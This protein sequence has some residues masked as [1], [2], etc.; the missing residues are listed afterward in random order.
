MA[1]G[2]REEPKYYMEMAVEVMKNSI[3][4]RNQTDPSP[5]VGAVLVFPN[6]DVNTAYRGQ[7]REGDHAEYTV[8]DK[9]NRHRD[10]SE[11]W[12]FATL[13]PCAPGA[14]KFPKLS[15]ANRIVNARIS[16]VWFG[17][18]ELNSK[19]SGG[20]QYLEA[21]GIEVLQFENEFLHEIKKYNTDFDNW[22]EEEERRRQE[23]D[24]PVPDGFLSKVVENADVNSLSPNALKSYID[25]SDKSLTLGSKELFRDLLDKNIL[26]QPTGLDILVPSGDGILLFGKSPRDKFPQSSVKA[27]VD[28]GTGE[29]DVQSF[30]DALV[31]IPD[32][33]ELWLKKVI[34]ESFDR[35]KFTREKIAHFPPEIIREAI[36]NAIVHRDYSIQGAKVQL[37]ITPEKIVVKSPGGPF[38][39]NTLEKLQ[40]FSAT[41]Y[42]RNSNIAFIFNIMR[43]MEETRVGMDTYKSLRDKFGLPLPIITFED[44]F[45]VVTFPRSAQALSELDDRLKQLNE[46]ELSGF[47]YVKSKGEVSKAEYALHFGF[48]EKKAQRHLLKMKNI[49]LLS[50]IGKST[51]SKYTIHKNE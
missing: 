6:G 43:L 31:L 45:L 16:K 24:T 1:I 51:T 30:D 23:K 27:K 34:P 42:T 37:E 47:D 15:C 48:D 19:A 4:E 44:P 33:V 11:C 38:W 32:Q 26:I 41:S 28:Y 10:L 8:L 18:Q 12:L 35:K 2:K 9:M 5:F 36:V 40:N 13:E 14:R 25:R 50:L 20:R 46:E 39:P 49:G 21:M 3:Q 17:V 7:F 22:V 29:I